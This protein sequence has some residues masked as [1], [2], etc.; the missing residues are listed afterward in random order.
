MM[1]KFYITNWIFWY[2]VNYEDEL[3]NFRIIEPIEFYC[4]W[5]VILYTSFVT[6]YV[7]WLSAI[8][9]AVYVFMCF[10]MFYMALFSQKGSM[11]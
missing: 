11:E 8:L 1:T 7:W 3:L 5:M 10:N 4:A 2:F 9:W 6:E